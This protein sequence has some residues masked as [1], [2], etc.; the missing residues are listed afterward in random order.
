[1]KTILRN[2]GIAVA[3][4]SL[5]SAC[6]GGSDVSGVYRGDLGGTGM[7]VELDFKGDGKATFAIIQGEN[8]Q[9]MDCTYE[10][11]EQTILVSCFGSSGISLTKLDNGDLEGNMDGTIVRYEKR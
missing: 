10:T 7:A 6:G 9:P 11:G 4:L 5:L 1:M 2:P 8:R 3:S